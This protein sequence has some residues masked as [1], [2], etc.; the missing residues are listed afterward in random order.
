MENRVVHRLGV[1]KEFQQAERGEL[2][3]NLSAGASTGRK[4]GSV[5]QNLEESRNNSH[6]FIT[7]GP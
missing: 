7:Y 3:V 2:I 5:E 6:D 4:F 1:S